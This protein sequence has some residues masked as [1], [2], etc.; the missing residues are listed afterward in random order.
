MAKI[1][2]VRVSAIDQNEARQIEALRNAG[3]ADEDMF[4]DKQSGKNDDREGLKDLLAYVRRGDVVITESISRIARNTKDLLNIVEML[5]MKG[6]DF[7]SQKEAIDT[8]TP[9]GKFMLTVFGAMAELERESILERQKEGIAIAKAEGK[10]KGRKPIQVGDAFFAVTKLW[11]E[12]AITC[13]EAQ[14]RLGLAPATFF[15]KCKEY[16]I[17]KARV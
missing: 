16:G 12:G 7:V 9:Q 13:S 14:K 2:Y 17:S 6:V 5:K 3:V 4:I 8:T 10:Y 1:G 11:V 15:R